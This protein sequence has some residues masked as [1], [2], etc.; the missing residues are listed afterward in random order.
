MPESLK[1]KAQ[2]AI[3][4]GLVAKGKGWFNGAVH[5]MA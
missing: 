1:F 5:L 2:T 4:T 3:Q